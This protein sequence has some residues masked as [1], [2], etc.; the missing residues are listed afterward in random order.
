[1]TRTLAAALALLAGCVTVDG[2]EVPPG[3]LEGYPLQ[4]VRDVIAGDTILLEDGGT[5]R[6]VRYAGGLAPGAGTQLA[7]AAKAENARLVEGQ[8]V[9][10]VPVAE[11]GDVTWGWVFV[12][13][14][15]KKLHLTVQWELARAGLLRPAD[16]PHA[17]D[18]EWF[19][20]LV[21]R[22]EVARR[23]R[24]GLWADAPADR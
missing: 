17:L 21:T 24:L 1:M 13:N 7:G 20:E 22:A 8:E 2:R 15:S 5:G 3:K 6:R 23:L 16:L 4:R 10:V 18:D 11:E 19:D 12:P 14:S 9:R